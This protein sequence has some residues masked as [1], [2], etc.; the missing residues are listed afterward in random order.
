MRRALSIVIVPLTALAIA[1]CTGGP[2]VVDAQPSSTPRP[3]PSYERCSPVTATAIDW[4]SRRVSTP[5]TWGSR[6]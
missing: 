6:S 2:G 4:G 3:T 1:G 5:P